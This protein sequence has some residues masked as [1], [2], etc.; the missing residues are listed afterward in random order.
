M[1][2][3]EDSAIPLSRRSAW[4]MNPAQRW[5]LKV[6]VHRFPAAPHPDVQPRIRRYFQGHSP[7]HRGHAQRWHSVYAAASVSRLRSD[8]DF[9]FADLKTSG[10]GN[11][12]FDKE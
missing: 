1:L 12:H 6:F 11:E 8:L 2:S 10:W 5:F 9:T 7:A 4:L 3:R